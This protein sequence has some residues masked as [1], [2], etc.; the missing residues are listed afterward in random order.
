MSLAIKLSS[1]ST[2][3]FWEIPVLFE[4]E[5]L[6][7]LDKPVGLPLT[8]TQPDKPALMPLLH[9]AIGAG[10]SWAMERKLDFLSHTHRLDPEASGVV[11]L[12][13]TKAALT[14]LGDRFGGESPGRTCLALVYGTPRAAEF[15]VNA[16]L[17][18]HPEIPEQSRLDLKE[19]KKS[20]TRFR[21]GEMFTG[22]AL[23]QCEPVTDRPQQARLHL[24]H[25]GLRVVGDALHGGGP[26]YLSRLKHDY[27]LKPGREE[28]PLL[29]RVSLHAD[30]IH[31][32][33]PVT[34]APLTITA[35]WPKDLKV[36]VKYLRQYAAGTPIA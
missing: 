11:L 21:V 12:A 14:A 15:E 5:Y 7:G 29:D 32:P 28:R 20:C 8:D 4:D 10:K 36:A 19:G 9:A 17:S 3:E 25:A 27:R 22:F 23:M 13:K 16:R 35:P 30:S 34:G 6:L 33:H 2:R 1:P 26:L 18:P 24:R 31:L